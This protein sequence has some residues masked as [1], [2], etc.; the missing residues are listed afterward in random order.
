MKRDRTELETA[1]G[2]ANTTEEPTKKKKKKSKVVEPETSPAE[3]VETGEASPEKK[4]KKKKKSKESTEDAIVEEKKVVSEEPEKKKKKKKK[5]VE[6]SSPEES[7]AESV[8]TEGGAALARKGIKTTTEDDPWFK[9][10]LVTIKDV[11]PLPKPCEKFQEAEPFLGKTLSDYL[12]KKFG[13]DGKP[14]LIQA[15][16]WPLIMNGKDMFGIAKTGSGKTLGFLAPYFAQCEDG[17]FKDHITKKD[18]AVCPRIV[19]LA[20]TKELIQQIA[21]V[22][23]EFSG[24]LGKKKYPV[25]CLIGGM[26]KGVQIQNIRKDGCDMCMATPGRL[27]DLM[28]DGVICLS[29]TKFLVLDEGDRMLDMGFIQDMRRVSE[30]AKFKTR[31]TVFFSATWP[32]EVSKLAKGLVRESRQKDIA[33]VTVASNDGT[34]GDK[35]Q[36]N[37]DIS[38]EVVCMKGDRQKWDLLQKYLNKFNGKKTIVF[39]LYKKE[40]ARIEEWLQKAGYDALAIQG[41]MT[42]DKRNIAMDKFRA[43]KVQIL[44]ATD[45]A[46]RGLDIPDVELVLNYTFPL[47]IED[48]VHRTG[49]TGRAGKK[50]NAVT[51]F[52]EEGLHNEKEHV[53]NLV[54]LL[55]GAKQP[56]SADLKHL[57]ANTFTATKKKKHGM[58]GDFFKSEEEMAKLS[59]KKVQVT[60][61]DSE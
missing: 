40:V 38:Q 3:S 52:N 51:F 33:T 11:F 32:L 50:G 24:V 9:K 28:N 16:A 45:V 46:A 27:L 36:F 29:Q 8:E 57:N 20:P 19:C 5:A 18:G 13:A 7:P 48:L 56:V 25:Q 47:T 34:D 14:S 49:R 12:I 41:D 1:S 4:K 58:Y 10:N 23:E 59:A 30:A 44:V 35:R 42:Q 60:F 6:E 17:T 22:A 2:L 53:F 61:S 26:P 37:P 31:Q 15:T 21:V 55:E 43:N 39:G 54:Q